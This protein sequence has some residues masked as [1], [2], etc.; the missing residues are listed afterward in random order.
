MR[1]GIYTVKIN[2]GVEKIGEAAFRNLDFV[3]VEMPN[4]IK[5]IDRYAFVNCKYL[6]KVVLSNSIENIEDYA[7]KDCKNLKIIMYK[8]HCDNCEHFN[9]NCNSCNQSYNVNDLPKS[10]K[11][12]GIG[13]FPNCCCLNAYNNLNVYNNCELRLQ[14]IL[15]FIILII[16]FITFYKSFIV[17][18]Y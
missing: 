8:R 7:F 15:L 2:N 18:Y 11:H 10:L 13:A 14:T 9:E 1:D 3:N 12:V 6:E 17:H 4:S 5:S 16:N